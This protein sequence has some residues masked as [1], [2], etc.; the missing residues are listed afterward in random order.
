MRFDR[1]SWL[2]DRKAGGQNRAVDSRAAR[3][4]VQ[5]AYRY[6]QLADL[7]AEMVANGALAPGARAPSVRA[8]SQQHGVSVSTVLQAYRTLEDRGILVAR[9]QS[10]FYVAVAPRGALALP[11]AS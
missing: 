1:H 8:V 3:M 4:E 2:A 10:G 9:P 11:S 5:T 7:V 6:E